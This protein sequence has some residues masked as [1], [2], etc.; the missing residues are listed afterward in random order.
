ME[1]TPEVLKMRTY[2]EFR[3]AKIIPPVYSESLGH[4]IGADYWLDTGEKID[5]NE[6]ELRRLNFLGG[7][8]KYTKP[9]DGVIKP[10]AEKKAPR[11]NNQVLVNQYLEANGQ[12]ADLSEA[13]P[14]LS[15]ST[16]KVYRHN[17]MKLCGTFTGRKRRTKAEMAVEQPKPKA[18]RTARGSG[19][20]ERVMDYLEANG[21]DA[22]LSGFT[23][24][25][26]GS[27]A[28]YRSM[29]RKS[30]GIEVKRGRK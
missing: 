9:V 29:F 6:A 11:T 5:Y 26:A 17:F 1:G 25:N 20:Q 30:K 24:I 22:D 28:V 10:I 7:R 18:K 12:D 23:D 14:D 16:L 3:C 4:Y 8:K 21:H 13:F 19:N 27:L 2:L 15:V